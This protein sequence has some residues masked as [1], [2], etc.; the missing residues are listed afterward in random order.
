V[1]NKKRGLCKKLEFKGGIVKMVLE[2][3]SRYSNWA[4]G[5]MVWGSSLSRGMRIFS[6]EKHPDQLWAP[7]SLLSVG[8]LVLSWR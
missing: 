7:H 4:T 3:Y 1:K 5:W 6:S 2:D 8:M